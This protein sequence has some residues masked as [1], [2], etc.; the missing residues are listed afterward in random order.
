[1][2]K[3]QKNIGKRYAEKVGIIMTD[4]EFVLSIYED[5]KYITWQSKMCI[6][7]RQ[8]TAYLGGRL[9]KNNIRIEPEMCIRDS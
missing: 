7:D 2:E 3:C 1:M 5:A 4:K 6:R 9:R 8:V